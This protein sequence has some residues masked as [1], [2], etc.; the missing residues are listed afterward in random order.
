M[1]CTSTHLTSQVGIN[2][3]SMSE[4]FCT[5]LDNVVSP[6]LVKFQLNVV[7]G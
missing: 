5:K 3:L 1:R 6:H 2:C 7:S 4:L